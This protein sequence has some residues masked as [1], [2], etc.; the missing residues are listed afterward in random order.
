MNILIVEDNQNR[1][2]QFKE[3]LIGCSV[4]FAWLSEAAINLIT[5]KEYD[6]IFLDYDIHS[7]CD[8]YLG[9]FELVWNYLNVGEMKY[10]PKLVLHTLNDMQRQIWLPT[11]ARRYFVIDKPFAWQK[12]VYSHDH[13]IWFNNNYIDWDQE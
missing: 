12:V 13:G 10:Y 1:I 3:K 5:A 9:S 4:D 8:L 6:Y 7:E 11:L 2:K